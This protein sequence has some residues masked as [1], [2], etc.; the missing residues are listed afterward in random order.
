M[1]KIQRFIFISVLL[2]VADRALSAPPVLRSGCQWEAWST[3]YH[4]NARTSTSLGCID[5]ALTPVW[6]YT[7]DTQDGPSSV[8][9]LA[10]EPDALYGNLNWGHCAFISGGQFGHVSGLQI[11]FDGATGWMT[12][13]GSNDF[14]QEGFPTVAE[15]SNTDGFPQSM[16]LNSDIGDVINNTFGVESYTIGGDVWGQTAADA[17]QIY[18]VNYLAVDGPKWFVRALDHQ[19]HQ[20][21]IANNFDSGVRMSSVLP[22]GIAIDGSRLFFAP[23][24]GTYPFPSGV[25]AYDLA[26]GTTDWYQASTPQSDISAG[27]GRVYLFEKTGSQLNLVARHET[28]GQLLWSQP[29]S[30]FFTGAPVYTGNQ[31]IVGVNNG[32]EAFDPS[33]GQSLWTN[34]VIP[35]DFPA[36]QMVAMKGSQTLVVLCL[37][38]QHI[39]VLGLNSGQEVWVSTSTFQSLALPVASGNRLYVTTNLGKVIALESVSALASGGSGGGGTSSTPGVRVYPNP[40]RGN[41]HAGKPIT[42]DQMNGNSTVKIFTED[43]HWVKTLQASSG[44]VTWDLTNDSGNKVASGLYL[45]LVSDGSGSS[46]KGKLAIIK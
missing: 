25:Y 18:Q 17:T 44:S 19:G 10:A 16:I 31:V 4:D 7:P 35:G 9:A 29:V 38:D 13:P 8:F 22:S 39:H 34:A 21:W 1:K 14:N 41:Q 24:Y 37:I 43:A 20:K 2:M 11:T 46:T 45:Y 32:I 15:A 27:G 5:G 28:D 30:S 42:F 26:T 33:S 6:T 12:C 3:I 40:W 23:D 36:T